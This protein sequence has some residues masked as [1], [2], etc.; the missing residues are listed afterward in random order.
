MVVNLQRPTLAPHKLQSNTTNA[1]LEATDWNI[2]TWLCP[3]TYCGLPWPCIMTIGHGSQDILIF[4]VIVH[5][6]LFVDGTID[7]SPQSIM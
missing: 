2:S 3:H 6:L 1:R 5:P 4:S 7:R